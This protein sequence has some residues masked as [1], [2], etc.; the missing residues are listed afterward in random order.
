MCIVGATRF[1]DW[2]VEY[3]QLKGKMSE[4]LDLLV[5]FLFYFFFEGVEDFPLL[6]V[7]KRPPRSRFF[8]RSRFCCCVAGNQGMSRLTVF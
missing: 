6:V 1:E 3:L 2:G 7:E 4:K 8:S 5:F